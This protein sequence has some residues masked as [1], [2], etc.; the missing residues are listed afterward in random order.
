MT[1]VL[2]V[3][4]HPDDEVLGVGGTIAKLAAQGDEVW[5]VVLTRASP[6]LFTEEQLTIGRQEA[7]AAHQVLGVRE[8]RFLPFP[9]V[10][11]DTVPQWQVNAALD[12]V[13]RELLPDVVFLPFGGDLHLDHRLAHTSGLVCARPLS[14]EAPRRVYCYETLSETNWSGPC[15]SP[16]FSPNVF[17]DIGAHLEAKIEAMQCYASQLKSGPTER[18]LG[19]IRALALLRG[20]TVGCIAAEAFVLIRDI[21]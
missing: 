1:R 15:I 4:P 19:A 8:T 12:E 14:G 18:S 13:F 11:L 3:A 7:R 9:A 17:V 21:H 10:G 6:P 20:A 2:V 5:V 16:G